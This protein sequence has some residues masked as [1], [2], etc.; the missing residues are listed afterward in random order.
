M[1]NNLFPRYMGW[2]YETPRKLDFTNK[3]I[4][5]AYMETLC[6]ALRNQISIKSINFSSNSITHLGFAHFVT[7]VPDNLKELILLNNQISH[8]G[9]EMLSPIIVDSYLNIKR[10]NL[11]NNRIRD[12]GA[13]V[14]LEALAKN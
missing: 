2:N 6:V 14:I 3:N 1:E 8:Q 9:C 11:E 13:C 10:L 12:K 4:G 7:N 5:D